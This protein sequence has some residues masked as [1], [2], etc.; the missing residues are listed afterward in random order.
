MKTKVIMARLL[1]GHPIR[2][3]SKT[4]MFNA[5]DLIGAAAAIR[6]PGDPVKALWSYFDLDSTVELMSE[7]CIAKQLE[8]AEVKQA[9]R[10]RDGGTWIHPIVMVDLAMWLSPTLKV[11]ILDWVLDGLLLARNESGDSFKGMCTA[12]TE[13]FPAEMDQRLSYCRVSEFIATACQVGMTKDRWQ[14]AT[15]DQLK[16]RDRIQDNIIILADVTANLGD[17]LTTSLRKAN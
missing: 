4:E 3:D 1:S 14:K 7:I 9:R 6:K 15:E 13:S 12:L 10:G 8:M 5:N 16:L 2:Q 11:A 17:C